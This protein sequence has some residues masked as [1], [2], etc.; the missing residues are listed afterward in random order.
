MPEYLSPGVFIEEVP[1]GLKAIE[2]VST[3]TAAFVGRARRGTVPGYDWKN[4]SSP[5][6]PFTPTRG[7]VLTPDP[8]PVLVT[9]FAE[10]QRQFGQ[11]LPMPLSKDDPNDYGY[12]GWAVRAFFD[13]GGKRVYISRVTDEE[14][15]ASKMRVAQGMVYRLMRS[16]AAGDGT[17]L[18]PL[19]FTSTR[20]LNVND[21]ILFK[22]HSDGTNALG[23]PAIPATLTGIA[24]PFALK[25]GDELN[26]ITNTPVAT[27]T[28]NIVAKPATVQTSGAAPFNVPDGAT[29]GLRIGPATEPIQTIVFSAADPLAPITVGAATVAEVETVLQ[30]YVSGVKV[31]H[32]AGQVVMETDAHGTAA[33][34]EIVAG[35][36]VAPLGLAPGVTGPPAGSTVPD[37]AHTTIAQL[38]ALLVSANFTVDA[39]GGG[40]LRFRSSA[41]GA[42]VTIKLDEV[43]PGSGLVQRLGFGAV[44]TITATGAA[45][46]PSTIQIASYN[47]QSNSITLTTPLSGP[48]DAN[49]AYAFVTAPVAAPPVPGAGPRVFARTPG[50]WSENISVA[51]SNADRSPTEV[52]GPV[53][54]GVSKLPVQSVTGLYKGAI[55]E[56]DHNGTSRSIHQITDINQS[57]R[58]ITID[59]AL[60]APALTIVVNP[61]T[62][63]PAWVRVLEIDIVVS[64]LT[65]AAPAEVYPGLSWNQD[66][67]VADL[68]RH[69]AKRIN[70]GSRLVWIQPPGVGSPPLSGTEDFLLTHQPITPH[71]FPLSPTGAEIGSETWTP[72]PASDARWVGLDNGPGQR[73]GI[74]SLKD[75]TEARIIAAPGKTS[76]TIQL[77]LIA[78]CEI[79]RYRFAI[80]DGEQDPI[81]GSITSILTHRNLYDTSF[82]AYYSPWVTVSVD[83]QNR[84]LPASG[85]MAGIYARVDNARGVWKAPANEPV[86]NVIGLKTYFTTGEQ[87][88]LNPRGVN[89][90]RQFDIDGIRVW[91]ARTLSSDP[92][93]KYINVRRTLIFLEASIDRGTQWVVFEPNEP[94]T[95]VRLT[96]SVSAFL[97][98]Q[99]RSGALFGRK[100]QE[101]FFVRCDEST[102]TS[103]DI[104]NGRLI[105]EIGVAIVRP[106]EFVIFRIEQ[107]VKFGAAT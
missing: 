24:G 83:G 91:G 80:L 69:Y 90:I 92:D 31:F 86:L 94:E 73:S 4:P 43:P 44:A 106:A 97:L 36:A 29:L 18:K 51:I 13:N 34:I 47:L 66:P 46:I 15:S 37:A 40:N 11:P 23:A 30:R 85:Y 55:I 105:C 49:D 22:R 10:F 8:S 48:L 107:I 53:L 99:W 59:P 82:A 70:A 16:A 52:T 104:L 81:G 35:T 100:P 95:W 101:A 38:A 28:A 61:L 9:S 42:T 103:D 63:L 56:V 68:R 96:D 12:L 39:D 65:G 21:T 14:D 72:T 7:F 17:D 84:Y 20:G 19:H 5:N 54:T 6:L 102:M 32:N 88:L 58:I 67:N 71:G 41:V 25:D 1:S 33:R 76:Q 2:G 57:T 62:D 89:L 77:A 64:D 79:L 75:L 78:Q 87:D 74:E 60:P 3:S 26:V 27:V 98:T 45:G 50:S 93:V